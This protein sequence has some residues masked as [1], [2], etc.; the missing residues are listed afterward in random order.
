MLE[1]LNKKLNQKLRISVLVLLS[2]Q[3][4]RSRSNSW[5]KKN[6]KTALTFPATDRIVILVFLAFLLKKK[7]FTFSASTFFSD[8]GTDPELGLFLP[9]LHILHK[10]SRQLRPSDYKNESHWPRQ[11]VQS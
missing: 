8:G 5:E 9:F 10:Q 7:S 1:C 2:P 11:S 3:L 4:P 6:H